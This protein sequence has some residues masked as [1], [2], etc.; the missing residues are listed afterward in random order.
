MRE[1]DGPPRP[2]SVRS[3][4][5]LATRLQALRSW[6]GV[7]YRALHR[8][9]LRGRRERGVAELPAFDTVHR[10]LQTGRTRIDAELVVDVAAAL[11]GSRDLAAPWRQACQVVAQTELEAR[12][13]TV[14][15]S[16][17]PDDS[18][19]VGRSVELAEVL[20]AAGEPGSVVTV[21]GMGGMGK[22]RLAVRAAH[23]LTAELGAGVVTFFVDLRG[24]DT[25]RPPA[26]PESVLDAL[27]KVLGVPAAR[28][29]HLDLDARRALLRKRLSGRPAVLV[30]D[31]A[32]SGAQVLPVLPD[33]GACRVVVTSRHSLEGVRATEVQLDAFAARD[34]TEAL[35]RAAHPT[36]VDVRSAQAHRIV[37]LVGRHPLAL[38]LVGA[39]VRSAPGWTLADHAERLAEARLAG[40]LDAGIDVALG[41]SY[42]RLP[43]ESRRMLR[44]VALHPG[45]DLDTYAAAALLGTSLA[46]ADA[47]LTELVDASLVRRSASGRFSLHDLVRTFASHRAHEEDPASARRAATA[48]LLD[49]HDAVM[50]RVAPLLFPQVSLVVPDGRGLSAT[51][52][53]QL[54]DRE[55]AQRWLDLEWRNLVSSALRLGEAER[56]EHVVRLSAHLQRHL[57]V[58]GHFVEAEA[59]HSAAADLATGASRAQALTNMASV[60][61]PL[62][63]HGDAEKHLRDALTIYRRWDNGPGECKT[64]NNLGI[65]HQHAGDYD[66]ARRHFEA[67]LGMAPNALLRSF[68]LA[69][70]AKLSTRLGLHEQALSYARRALDEARSVDDPT[71]VAQGL[72]TVGDQLRVMGRLDEARAELQQSL[73]LARS[74]RFPYCEAFALN[75]LGL[76]SLELGE[77]DAAERLQLEALD[78]AREFGIGAVEVVVLNALGTTLRRLG[79]RAD[80]LASYDAALLLASDT[81]DHHQYALAEEGIR[82]T[83]PG[84]TEP[85]PT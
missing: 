64:L 34:A 84:A 48:R 38:S 14:S 29:V 69:N 68:P 74:S 10:C 67:A 78:V 22:T 16:M 20:A 15:D 76:V 71:R 63:R 8:E 58:G 4:D 47:S 39:R 45:A 59:L 53:P 24:Y 32:S 82:A 73:E 54:P 31:N 66:R 70:L 44:L 77:V 6:A 81:G 23:R 75:A 26:D 30:L 33:D 18:D 12:L 85:A 25:E 19:F 36:P 17:P 56:P 41:L 61:F 52:E 28:L 9:V 11:L 65:V 83:S 35:R 21:M 46:V 79:R 7:S 62:G 2:D 42:D 13:V 50:T 80:A 55:A 60:C 49:H 1:A 43:A 72:F 37:E 27:L 5:E 57:E 40:R 3:L 51:P